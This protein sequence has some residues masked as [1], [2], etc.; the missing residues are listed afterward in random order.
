MFGVS[1]TRR[2]MRHSIT[3]LSKKPRESGACMLRRAVPL[4]TCSI[5]L[6]LYFFSVSHF[7]RGLPSLPRDGNSRKVE[8]LVSPDSEKLASS[9]AFPGCTYVSLR[10]KE[11]KRVT[12]AISIILLKAFQSSNFNLNGKQ[13][14]PIDH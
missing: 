13:K 2:S 5:T 3:E 9:S 14:C 11:K 6:L 8:A 4:S 10:V 1:Y 7:A 12:A